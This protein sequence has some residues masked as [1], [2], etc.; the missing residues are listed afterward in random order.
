[1]AKSRDAFRTISEVADW[2]DTPAHVLRF[3]ESKFPQIKPVKRAGGRR[4]YRPEDMALLGGIKTLLHEDGLTIKGAQKLLR[5]KGVRHVSSLGPSPMDG[6]EDADGI[7]LQGR[8]PET[9]PGTAEDRT[10]EDMAGAEELSPVDD[11]LPEVAPGV[12]P[13]SGDTLPAFLRRSPGMPVPPAP[14]PSGPTAPERSEAEAPDAPAAT[15]EAQAAAEESPVAE[16]PP[17]VGAKDS[18]AEDIPAARDDDTAPAD[19]AET[20][21]RDTSAPDGDDISD[22]AAPAAP[23]QAALSGAHPLPQPAIREAADLAAALAGGDPASISEPRVIHETHDPGSA[24]QPELPFGS[25]RPMP[26]T[27]PAPRG[28]GGRARP[29]RSGPASARPD[30]LPLGTEIRPGLLSL[31]AD[32]EALAADPARL[33][34]AL[35][36]LEALR[37]RPAP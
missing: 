2:L 13:A 18:P 10:D 26:V 22:R 34:A 3:W 29:P 15:G 31:L 23:A 9:G 6:E 35:A 21:A 19:A 8:L 24:W 25:L 33:E 16:A 5:E 7:V 20:T 32:A 27:R 17:P 36:R 37:D 28:T 4:Y 11:G 14:I 12:A 30:G 1:M